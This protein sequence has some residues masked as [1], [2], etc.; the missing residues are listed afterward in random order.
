MKK[1]L[2]VLSAL[3]IVLMVVGVVAAAAEDFPPAPPAGNENSLMLNQDPDF[4]KSVDAPAKEAVQILPSEAKIE[5]ALSDK[6]AKM[7]PQDTVTVA[8]WVNSEGIPPMSRDVASTNSVNAVAA[9][10]AFTAAIKSR[11]KPVVDSL[12]AKKATIVYESTNAPVVFATVTKAHVKDLEVRADVLQ[13]AEEQSNYELHTNTATPSVLAPPAWPYINGAN[14]GKI[15]IVEPDG[16]VNNNPY[17]RFGGYWKP[18]SPMVNLYAGHATTCAGMAQSLHTTYPGVAKFT[19]GPTI[20]SANTISWLDSNMTAASDWAINSGA[21]ILSNSWGGTGL[22]APTSL[23]YMSKYFDYVV[24]N[25]AVTVVFSSGNSNASG[26]YIQNPA[27]AYNGITVGSYNDQQTGWIPGDDDMSYFS[28]SRD[29]YFAL[30]PHVVAAG[31]HN[32]GRTSNGV[33]IKSLST[34][35]PWYGDRGV[36]TSY[37]APQVAGEASMM[38]N[39]SPSLKSWP[40]TVKA[41]IMATADHNIEGASRYSD[42]DGAGGIN[43]L[44]ATK[45]V[46]TNTFGS[47]KYG[48]RSVT[49]TSMSSPLYLPYFTATGG[50]KVRVA[51]AYDSYVSGT[52]Y[53]YDTLN[54]DLDLDMQKWTGSAWV[55]DYTLGYSWSSRDNYEILEF[56]APATGYYRPVVRKYSWVNPAVGEYIGYAVQVR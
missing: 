47:A 43:V 7:G 31:A 30:K 50:Q 36:G 41:V 52:N 44:E 15:A 48:G 18:L 21:R 23:S 27:L 29:G 22:A 26:G 17:L 1:K 54:S 42:K 53:A 38:M 49:N 20:L 37:A 55:A 5:K 13:V 39:A 2:W 6:L 10:K 12:I 16:I 9:E 4:M 34:A 24:R 19:A 45:L 14:A 3:F 56:N 32:A 28:T 35:S 25:R 11:Q 33:G 51:I 8:I 40:E 46:R